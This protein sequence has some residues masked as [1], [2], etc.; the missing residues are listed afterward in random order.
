MLPRLN[1]VAILAVILGPAV[2]AVGI[3][4]GRLQARDQQNHALKLAESQQAHERR[5]RTG[6]RLFEKRGSVYLDLFKFVDLQIARVERTN[7]TFT[8]GPPEDPP[9]P[10][11][12]DEVARMQAEASV[13]GS[14]TV[15]QLVLE[16]TRA[17]TGF[18]LASSSLEA[19]KGRPGGDLAGAWETLNERRDVV[20]EFYN[21][22]R[23]QI[24][25]EIEN[26]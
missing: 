16:F 11:D 7:P 3:V 23:K 14:E 12:P 10:P 24:Q 25:D 13:W 19:V 2:G 8:L 4:F 15:W 22:I 9:D 17:V 6:D 5:L 21:K 18:Y 1:T 26:L 20:R